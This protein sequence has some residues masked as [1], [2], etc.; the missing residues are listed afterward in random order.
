MFD[1]ERTDM[2]PEEMTDDGESEW[3]EIW[4]LVAEVKE[5]ILLQSDFPA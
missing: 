4:E 1:E 5:E 2:W 3:G